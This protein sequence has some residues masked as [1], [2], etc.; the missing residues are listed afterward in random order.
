MIRTSRLLDMRGTSALCVTTVVTSNKATI[1]KNGT[2]A[3]VSYC[4]PR[5]GLTHHLREIRRRCQLATAKDAPPI[6]L[7]P[8]GVPR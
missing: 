2:V 1:S 8:P 6:R 4:A 5:L 3:L 7:L